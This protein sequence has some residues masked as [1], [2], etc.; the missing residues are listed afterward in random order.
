[1]VGWLAKRL[2]SRLGPWARLALV[3]TL[4]VPVVVK[5]QIKHFK[6]GK[7]MWPW[8]GYRHPW[9]WAWPRYGPAVPYAWPWAPISKE[10]EIAML[11]DQSR[12]LES[13]LDR[14]RSRLEELKKQEVKNA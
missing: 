9:R 8:Y 14:I 11:E 4:L 6:G 10:Q 3:C 13:E 7:N 1:M 2:G 12:M 5:P